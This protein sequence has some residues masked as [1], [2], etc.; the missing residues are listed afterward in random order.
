MLPRFQTLVSD[1]SS[2]LARSRPGSGV[3]SIVK[4][5]VKFQVPMF[6]ATHVHHK[7]ALYHTIDSYFQG[8]A[9]QTV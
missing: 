4:M 6:G 3:N 9:L 8:G 2:V 1:D 5:Y 7:M